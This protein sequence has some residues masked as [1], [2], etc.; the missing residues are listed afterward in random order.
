MKAIISNY[1][2]DWISE[3]VHE[4]AEADCVGKYIFEVFIAW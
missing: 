1:E 4:S 3:T 2:L